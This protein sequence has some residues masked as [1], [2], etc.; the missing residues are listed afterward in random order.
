MKEDDKDFPVANAKR[1]EYFKFKDDHQLWKIME[2]VQ[3]ELKKEIVKSETK[4]LMKLL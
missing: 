3:S 4:K 1:E 2:H